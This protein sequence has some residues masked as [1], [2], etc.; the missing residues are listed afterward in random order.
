MK[1]FNILG[2]RGNNRVLEGEFTKNNVLEGRSQY[3]GGIAKK[4]WLGQFIYLRAASQERGGGVF[5]GA[6]IPQCTT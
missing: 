2:V 3:I 1:N 5:K 4:G 6:L